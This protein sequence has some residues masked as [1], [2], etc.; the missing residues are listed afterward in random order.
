MNSIC[1]GRSF[2]LTS[3]NKNLWVLM[4][5][6]VILKTKCVV[7]YL[8]VLHFKHMITITFQTI[9][10]SSDLQIYLIM[11]EVR[12]IYKLND[13]SAH[14]VYISHKNHWKLFFCT[15]YKYFTVHLHISSVITCHKN[16][17][18]LVLHKSLFW[19][20]ESSWKTENFENVSISYFSINLLASCDVMRLYCIW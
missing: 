15:I 1:S 8:K 3:S 6:S 20:P 14:I 19:N 10:F 16:S 18:N 7:N 4:S 12:I 11:Q 13:Q 17:D 5:V 2:T 9:V